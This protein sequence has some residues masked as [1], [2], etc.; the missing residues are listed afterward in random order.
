MFSVSSAKGKTGLHSRG[1]DQRIGELNP[2][3]ESVLLD[4]GGGCSAD[5]FGKGK[6]SELELAKGLPDLARLQLRSGALKKLHEGDDGQGAIRRR[7][8]NAG[9]PFA[10]AGRPDRNIGVEDHFDFRKRS[11]FS[12]PV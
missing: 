7:V 11:C 3:C 8:D 4:Q 5:G 12:M 6:D 9:C 1:C 10:T 2:V